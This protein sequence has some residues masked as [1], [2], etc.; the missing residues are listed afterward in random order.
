M[1]LGISLVVTAVGAILR[2]AYTPTTS[3]GWNFSTMGTILMIIGIV[4]AVVS[5]IA[6]MA[7]SYRHQRMTS[8]TES[9][10]QVVRREDVDS[11]TTS[12]L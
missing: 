3:N 4:G 6:W 7:S 8:T 2:Y 10:G 1:A 11:R 9:G 5:V 12:P